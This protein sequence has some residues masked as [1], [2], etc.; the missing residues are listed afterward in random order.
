MIPASSNGDLSKVKLL[1]EKKADVNSSNYRGSTALIE[2]SKNGHLEIVKLLVG[3]KIDLEATDS[4][5]KKR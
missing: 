2:A 3:N 4:N 5:E 1:L